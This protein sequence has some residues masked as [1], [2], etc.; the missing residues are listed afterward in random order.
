MKCKIK[1]AAVSALAITA[2]LWLTSC[3]EHGGSRSVLPSEVNIMPR[4]VTI[5]ACNEEGVILLGGDGNALAFNEGFYFA[6]TLMREGYSKGD[7]FLP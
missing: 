1:L 5:L 2:L 3:G 4:P 6:Q 7:V